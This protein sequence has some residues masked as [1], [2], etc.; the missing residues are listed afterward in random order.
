MPGRTVTARRDAGDGEPPGRHRVRDTAAMTLVA[1]L[2]L[3]SAAG[4]V[5]GKSY[6]DIVPAPEDSPQSP[7]V[8]TT[9]QVV[10][11]TF[12]IAKPDLD[13]RFIDDFLQLRG[14]GNRLHAATDIMAP[15]HRPV[16]AAVGGTITFAPYDPDRDG[17]S[18]LGEPHY[19][20]M[21]SIRGDDG[22]RYSYV[23]LNND[24]PERV[25]GDDGKPGAWLDDD[26]GGIEHA[27][28]PRIVAAIH[29]HGTARGLRVERGELIGWNGD[30]GNA[31]GIAPHLHFEIE[32]T[33]PDGPYRI[34]PYHSLLDA[35]ERGDVPEHDSGDSE[36]WHKD[37]PETGPELAPKKDWRDHGG[38][39]K[40]VDPNSHHGPA[41]EELSR[42]GVLRGCDEERYCP[43]AAKER[44]DIAAAIAVALDLD[45]A[46]FDDTRF[47]DVDTADPRAAAIAAV[48]QA[49]V[50]TGYTDGTFGPSDPLTRAQLASVFVR[51]F[52][53]SPATRSAGFVD[54]G[55]AGVHTPAIDTLA[56][57]GLTRGCEDGT[58]FCGGEEER[59]DRVASF[60][61][62]GI[63]LT[64]R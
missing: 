64:N 1:L 49:G 13:V 42:S 55:P 61:Q 31:K 33:G 19:G 15:K 41:I 38:L 58:R 9:P 57:A 45:V 47:P 16:Y 29:K 18:E 26:V 35:L 59:R 51:A 36:H 32:V 7:I 37:A 27:Y 44:A 50:L 40:D 11:L 39:Y 20:W 24:T 3:A 25:I 23:H 5:T 56:Q 54:V 43:G 46:G 12:P 52:E 62:R 22:H 14:G 48:D 2:V 53:L 10:D 60:L 4:A 30:S 21:I 8:D 34:N 28:A 63:E 17:W 6:D